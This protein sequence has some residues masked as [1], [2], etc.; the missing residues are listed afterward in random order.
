MTQARCSAVADRVA[1]LGD[2][3]LSDANPADARSSVRAQLALEPAR[4]G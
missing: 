3:R 2:K 1:A 4:D